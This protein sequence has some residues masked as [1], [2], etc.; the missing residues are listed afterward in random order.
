MSRRG[1]ARFPVHEQL[2]RLE[3]G[4]PARHRCLIEVLDG[5]VAGAVESIA[6]GIVPGERLAWGCGF[7]VHFREAGNGDVLF[8]AIYPSGDP[9]KDLL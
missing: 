8:L 9:V 4:D 2:G 3:R 7:I 5:L 1:R 6:S